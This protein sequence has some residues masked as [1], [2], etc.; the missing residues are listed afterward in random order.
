[1]HVSDELA[2]VSMSPPASR[3][4]WSDPKPGERPQGVG[5]GSGLLV[6]EPEFTCPAPDPLARLV[7]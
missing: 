5:S 3:P 4:P 7:F 1:M 6:L 2:G